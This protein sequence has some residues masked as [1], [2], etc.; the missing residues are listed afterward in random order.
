[1][2]DLIDGIT[3]LYLKGNCLA[4]KGLDKNLHFKLKDIKF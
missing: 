2:L 3:G 1:L 4:G